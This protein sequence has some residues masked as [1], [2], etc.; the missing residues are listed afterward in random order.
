[1]KP[2]PVV[3]HLGPLQL[4]TYGLGLAITFWFAYRYLDR[5]L[6]A[7][8]YPSEW[9]GPVTVRVIVAAIVGAR[10]V[11]VLAHL[12]VYLAHPVQ[13]LEVW[14]GGLSSFGGLAL[15]LTTGFYLAHKRLPQVRLAVLADLVAPVLLASWA[16]GRLLGPQLMVRGGGHPTHQWFGLY[17]AGEVGKRL[18]VPLFQAAITFVVLLVV[19]RVERAAA[20]AGGP[21]GIVASVALG[22]WGAGRFT[23]EHLWLATGG[24]GHGG[25][26]AVEIAGIALA[27]VGLGTAAWLFVR[28]RRTRREVA[29]AAPPEP[30]GAR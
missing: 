17:Y 9:L 18:P 28:H 24:P 16:V 21:V 12:S 2:I 19:W 13:I 23:E 15:G 26:L 22:L 20:A 11:H 1:M 5:R 29:A 10:V 3:F 6:R 8:G 14:Q 25:A 27:A 7:H 4:H 30:V